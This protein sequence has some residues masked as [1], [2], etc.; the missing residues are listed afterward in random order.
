MFSQIVIFYNL[1][2]NFDNVAKLTNLWSS[3]CNVGKLSF[4]LIC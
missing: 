3:T 2:P 4:F 1:L